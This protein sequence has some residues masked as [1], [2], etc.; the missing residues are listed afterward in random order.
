MNDRII[1][2]DPGSEL[3]GMCVLDNGNIISAFNV[4]KE[5]LYC[6]LSNLLIH[7][8]V[9]VVI[10]DLAPYTLR[11][12]PS[13]I[14]T[15]KLIGELVYRLKIEISVYVEL[16]PR[17][18]VKK[19]VFDAV[20]EV[21]LP[22]INKKIEKKGQVSKNGEFR[23]PSFVYVDDNIVAKAVRYKRKI[24]LPKAGN[25][26]EHGLQKHS[27]Q[28]LAVADCFLAKCQSMKTGLLQTSLLQGSFGFQ[29]T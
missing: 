26:Y 14:D 7:S 6:K 23:K 20:P 19:W 16:I 3:S 4:T 28:A 17:S 24:P 27:W 18:E 25:G 21:C 1:G 2:I 13:V 29:A 12:T 5:Q 15:A 9:T 22:I 10:E 11:L 8:S